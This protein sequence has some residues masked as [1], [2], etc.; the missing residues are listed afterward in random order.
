VFLYIDKAAV[1]AQGAINFCLHIYLSVY[2]PFIRLKGTE[3]KIEKKKKFG[4]T[5]IVYAIM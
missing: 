4:F 3:K 1:S 5:Q 2:Y